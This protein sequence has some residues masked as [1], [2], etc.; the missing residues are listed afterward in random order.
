MAS[1]QARG[2]GRCVLPKARP[3][4]LPRPSSLAGVPMVSIAS[5]LLPVTARTSSS[6]RVVGRKPVTVV[7]EASASP[8]KP[9]APSFKWGA[10]MRVS[11]I[12]LARLA[13][14]AGR[15]G[16]SGAASVSASQAGTPPL[17][18]GPGHLRRHRHAAVVHPAAC[19]RDYQGLAP[20]GCLHRWVHAEAVN[21]QPNAFRTHER[22]RNTPAVR[23][24]PRTASVREPTHKPVGPHSGPW[25]R[26]DEHVGA[27]AVTGT[28]VGIITTPLPLGAVA[29]IGL[30]VSMITKVLTFAEAF[31]A[32]ASEIP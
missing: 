7:A 30:G 13:G 1:L 15:D 28:I 21:G 19:W 16:V 9:S 27:R 8:A 10:N 26:T 20:A 32:F 4:A 6:T 24:P 22:P 25:P 3:A 31:S 5:P 2:L 12:P 23:A 17:A 29:I 18:A 14:S 11:G